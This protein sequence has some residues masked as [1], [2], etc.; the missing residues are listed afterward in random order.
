M[1]GIVTRGD[2]IGTLV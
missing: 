1:L 2:I